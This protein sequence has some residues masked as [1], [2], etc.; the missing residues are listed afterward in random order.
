MERIHR[1][2]IETDCSTPTSPLRHAPP[3][4]RAQAREAAVKYLRID[5]P[6]ISLR[7][8]RTTNREPR[9]RSVAISVALQRAPRKQKARSSDRAF[10]LKPCSA[11]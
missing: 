3:Y 4:A 5:R 2:L 11:A 9:G 7:F 10:H 8:I 6:R 1:I